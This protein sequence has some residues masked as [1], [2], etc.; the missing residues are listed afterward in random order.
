LDG[1]ISAQ[2][3]PIVVD[4]FAV[5]RAGRRP[6]VY[7]LHPVEVVTVTRFA[8]IDGSVA[9]QI[10]ARQT[11]GLRNLRRVNARV[12]SDL[13]ECLREPRG[14]HLRR[15]AEAG[16]VIQVLVEQHGDF[17]TGW[18]FHTDEER[19]GGASGPLTVRDRVLGQG[20]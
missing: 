4:V 17:E 9:A 2:V 5:R 19:V 13:T 7:A 8:K 10:A 3:A 12:G 16:V 1:S 20:A 18:K 6:A 11:I 14:E 15:I